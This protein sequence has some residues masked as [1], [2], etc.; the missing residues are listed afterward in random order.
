[1]QNIEIADAGIARELDTNGYVVLP[2]ADAA[3]WRVCVVTSTTRSSL[4]AG[5]K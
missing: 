2:G 5:R 3:R 1:M 4:P